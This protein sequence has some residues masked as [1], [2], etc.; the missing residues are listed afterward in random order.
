MKV[1]RAFLV[2]AYSHPSAVRT[3][4]RA[5]GRIG[6]W[7]SEMEFVARHL[8]VEGRLLDLGCGAGRTTFGLFAAGYRKIVGA[9]LSPSM[10]RQARV[11]ASQWELKI[12]FRIADA[13]RLPFRSKS[14][15]GCLFSFN[16]LMTIPRRSRRIAALREIRRVLVPGGRFVF[17]T[18]ER[19]DDA[20]SRVVWREERALWRAGRQDPQLHEFGDQLID[21]LGRPT[22]IHVPD[23]SEILD[24]L[25]A[26]GL[27]WVEDEY[28]DLG[29]ESRA[30]RE[31]VTSKCR[32]WAAE[33]RAAGRR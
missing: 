19:L 11:N 27:Q 23:R 28:P 18:H 26:A 16:G 3:Y 33:K 15:E 12:P 20:L 22:F 21:E 25:K 29:R 6:L 10:V 17:T 8:Q 1:D 4:S 31:F 30:V 24:C 9:D 5:V 32:F 2:E 14:F 13:C 7:K